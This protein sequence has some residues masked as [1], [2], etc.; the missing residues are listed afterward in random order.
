MIKRGIFRV[1]VFLLI[2]SAQLI[3]AGA[4]DPPEPF[5][6][7]QDIGDGPPCQEQTEVVDGEESTTSGNPPPPGLCLPIN[8]YLLPLFISGLCLGSFFL[9]RNETEKV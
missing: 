9:L 2:F 7:A 8:D 5:A 3:S 4:T 1:P 6:T